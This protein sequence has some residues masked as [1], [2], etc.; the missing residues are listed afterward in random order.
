MFGCRIRRNNC[1]SC[2]NKDTIDHQSDRNKCGMSSRQ[3]SGNRLLLGVVVA[4]SVVAVAH[5]Q[6]SQRRMAD[7][8]CKV[9]ALG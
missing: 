7:T 9:L 5:K 6:N 3:C 2:S 4:L 1:S 8:D